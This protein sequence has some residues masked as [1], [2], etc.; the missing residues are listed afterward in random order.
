[1]EGEEKPT[2]HEYYSWNEKKN[3]TWRKEKATSR[4]GH[5]RPTPLHDLCKGMEWKKKR[6]ARKMKE[7]SIHK[8]HTN[9]KKMVTELSVLG[10][11]VKTLTR[12]IV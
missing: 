8:N 3:H 4:L 5:L 12:M 10:K 11:K 7:R 2:C 9:K 1:M 6:V